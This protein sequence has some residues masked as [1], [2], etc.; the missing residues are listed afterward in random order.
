MEQDNK[1]TPVS[2]NETKGILINGKLKSIHYFT[3][4]LI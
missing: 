3:T 4:L 2:G 1:A